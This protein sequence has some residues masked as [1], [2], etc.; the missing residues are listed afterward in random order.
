MRALTL[1]R[2]RLLVALG[3]VLALAAFA[4]QQAAPDV[5]RAQGAPSMAL[6]LTGTGVS[7]TGHD[8][9]VPPSGHFRAAAATNPAPAAGYIA[10]QIHIFYQGLTYLPGTAE[11]ENTWP[12]NKLP[13]R[14][15]NEPTGHE[16]Y[17]ALGGL[18]SAT[19]PFT[20]STFQG[21]LAAINMSCPAGGTYV[22]ALLSY[23][24][25]DLLGSAY[26]LQ[27]TTT[28]PAAP[29]RLLNADTDADTVAQAAPVA[30]W[31]NVNCGPATGSD[32]GGTVTLEPYPT[33]TIRAPATA[34]GAE[35]T[36]PATSA[37]GTAGNGTGTARARATA[38]PTAVGG[39]TAANGG[40]LGAGWIVLIV[41]LVIAAVGGAG[42]GGWWYWQQRQAGAEPP[43]SPPAS[44][45]PA[46][47]PPGGAP[48]ASEPPASEPPASEPPA[49]EPPASE[50][51]AT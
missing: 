19:P 6:D 35:L 28:V 46:G 21:E 10:V 50:P 8:C 48:P 51:L 13:V 7:C 23:S 34:V 36:P 43:G 22:L 32:V 18:A 49:S 15:P 20:V 14:S 37:S 26:N 5:A 31:K 25:Q 11:E 9:T 41:I 2:G 44:E 30:D 38:R 29:Q 24:E 40:G 47:G 16:G 33:G 45:P 3:A 42:Y 17:V 1:H 27:D 12:D 39:G 4:W